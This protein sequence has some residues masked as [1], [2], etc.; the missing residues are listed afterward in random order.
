MSSA[1][2][3]RARSSRRT[4]HT[5]ATEISL[6][7]RERG[8][9]IQNSVGRVLKREDQQQILADGGQACR[10]GDVI[11]P[12]CCQRL[13]RLS[14]SYGQMVCMIDMSADR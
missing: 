10:R 1:V 3:E 9:G 6:R 14:Y 5:E 8:R 2:E 13:G 11:M 7:E 12:I 4:A